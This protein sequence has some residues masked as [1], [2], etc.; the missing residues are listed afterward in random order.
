MS[1]SEIVNP[2]V[3][4]IEAV[5]EPYAD[6]ALQQAPSVDAV[7]MYL[8]KKYGTVAADTIIRLWE[9][10]PEDLRAAGSVEQI[11]AYIWDSLP[12]EKL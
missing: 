5:A 3:E 7:S 6:A 2:Y 9:K 10:L 8:E 1:Q 11:G 4:K 12:A